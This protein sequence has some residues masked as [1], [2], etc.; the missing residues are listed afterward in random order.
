MSDLLPTALLTVQDLRAG[1]GE[2]IVL[3]GG[4]TGGAVEEERRLY[5]VA[6]T[7]AQETLTLSE[8]TRNANPFTPALDATPALARTQ[9]RTFPAPDPDLDRQYTCRGLRH[10]S[11]KRRIADC[12]ASTNGKSFSRWCASLRTRTGRDLCQR[13]GQLPIPCN[14]RHY[15]ALRLTP[16]PSSNRRGVRAASCAAG[17]PRRLR[18]SSSRG[19]RRSP[20]ASSC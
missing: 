12:V 14:G 8:F 19:I 20:P 15:A 4:W 13:R 6:A 7:R 18:F 5:Y 9:P 3:D 2:A 10:R 17:L 1:Y 11:Q 16:R